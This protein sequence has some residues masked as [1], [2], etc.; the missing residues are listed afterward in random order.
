MW[1]ID[2]D[3]SSSYYKPV[4]TLLQYRSVLPRQLFCLVYFFIAYNYLVYMQVPPVLS[5]NT[6]TDK[7]KAKLWTL[8]KIK[9]TFFIVLI[10]LPTV[11]AEFG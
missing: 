1:Q 7:V 8:K 3:I 5:G 9:N 4:P 11:T 6:S 2:M 10:K